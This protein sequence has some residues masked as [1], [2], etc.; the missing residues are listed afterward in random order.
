M[1][2]PASVSREWRMQPIGLAW[3]G[4]GLGLSAAVFAGRDARGLE[5]ASPVDPATHVVSIELAAFD[6]ELAVD[7]RTTH[8]GPVAR[9]G[10]EIVR[11]GERVVARVT[12][13]WRVIQLYL[14]ASAIADAAEALGIP[15]SRARSLE[16]IPPRL[17][18]DPLIARLGRMIDARLRRGGEFFRL[19][20]DDVALTLAE[21]LVRRHSTVNPPRRRPPLPPGTAEMA[22]IVALLR[23]HPDPGLPDIGVLLDRPLHEAERAFRDALRHAPAGIIEG[24]S[25][26]RLQ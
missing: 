6:L 21:R 4:G 2:N 14:P 20:L 25:G 19:E 9:D 24:L 17:A 15:D 3:P 23:D 8:A 10:C 16:L 11:G 26:R 5:L 1:I 22:A 7:G 18:R 13:D 12:G